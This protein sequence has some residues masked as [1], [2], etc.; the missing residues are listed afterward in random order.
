MSTPT[1]VKMREPGPGES[2]GPITTTSEDVAR[3]N[4]RLAWKRANWGGLRV[5]RGSFRCPWPPTRVQYQQYEKAAREEWV[6]QMDIE[7]WDFKEQFAASVP[8]RREA[9]AYSGDYAIALPGYV[10]IPVLGLF[11]KRKVERQ[12]I[13]VPVK[14]A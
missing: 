2:D 8:D 10:E 4:D 3:W 1:L 6:R 9:T 11:Q 7:G 5:L 14:V 12:R 13:E